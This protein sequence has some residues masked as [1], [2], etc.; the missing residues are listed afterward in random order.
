MRQLVAGRIFAFCLCLIFLL[1]TATTAFAADFSADERQKIIDSVAVALNRNLAIGEKV[2]CQASGFGISMDSLG[3]EISLIDGSGATLGVYG[4]SSPMRTLEV[5]TQKGEKFVGYCLKAAKDYPGAG[6]STWTVKPWINDRAH[7]KILWV[8]ENSWPAIPMDEMMGKAGASLDAFYEK[9]KASNPT[10]DEQYIQIFGSREKFL[11]TYAVQA[12]FGTVQMAIW[13]HEGEALKG[14]PG[15]YMGPQMTKGPEDLIKLY[16]YLCME[17]GEYNNYSQHTFGRSVKINRLYGNN[18]GVKE[19]TEADSC[20]K[21][22]LF[23][24]YKVTSDLIQVGNLSV[25][26]KG[27]GAGK[28]KFVSTTIGANGHVTAMSDI[29]NV[30]LNQDFFVF[31]GGDVQSFK[32]QLEAKTPNGRA[33]PENGRGR[34][35]ESDNNSAVQSVG[36][37]CVI[38]TIPARDELEEPHFAA[39]V[40]AKVVISKT[41]DDERPLPGAEIVI[42]DKATSKEVFRGVTDADGKVTTGEL[43][44]GNYVFVE[45]K[46]PDGYIL[47]NKEHTFVVNEDGTVT[48]EQSLANRKTS[49]EIQKIDAVTGAGVAGAQIGIYRA[50]DNQQVTT[51]T[52]GADGKAVVKGLAAGNYYAKET[53]PPAGYKLNDAEIPF[54]I[55]NDG[56]TTPVV[57]ITNSREGRQVR[58]S[59]DDAETKAPV[60][61]AGVSVYDKDGNEV[62]KGTTNADGEVLTIPLTPGEYT[63]KETSAPAGYELNREVFKFTLNEDGSISG[64]TAFSNTPLKYEVVI[65]K[66]RTGTTTPVQG[67]TITVY[68]Q[69]GE[70]VH[71]ARTDVNGEIRISNLKPG[72]YTFKETAAPVG[73]AKEDGTYSFDV[74]GDGRVSGTTS[75]TNDPLRYD[76]TLKKLDAVN[77]APLKGATLA[78]YD[79][80]GKNVLSAVTDDKGEIKVPRLLPGKYTFKETAAPYGYKLNAGSFAFEVGSDGKVTGTTTLTNERLRYDVTLKK[81]DASNNNAP[82]K[83]ATLAVYDRDGK[84]IYSAVTDDKGEIKVPQLLPGKYTFKEVV[85][86][87]GYALNGNTFTFEVGGDGKVTGATTITN[88]LLWHD[89]TIKKVDAANNAPLKGAALAVYNS[90]GKNIY[91]A[92]TDDKGEI[93]VSHLMPGKYTV[94]ETAAPSGYTLNVNS[95][96][97][98]VGSDGK[99]T[100]ATT[101]ADELIRVPVR[102]VDAKNASVELSGATFSLYRADNNVL[103][104][105]LTTGVT[106]ALVLDTQRTI[107]NPSCAK[108]AATPGLSSVS[109]A[110]ARNYTH[111][112]VCTPLHDA[113]TSGTVTF[114]GMPAGKYYIKETVAPKG[115]ALSNEVIKLEITPTYVNPANP[116][117]IKD[118]PL[119]QTGAENNT[120]IGVH[121]AAFVTSVTVLGFFGIRKLRAMLGW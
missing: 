110:D 80:T 120:L 74:A 26:I 43:D 39:G 82:L 87:A 97:F 57:K 69:A 13:Y 85:A 2:Y 16:N 76:V 51:V 28:C 63:F 59:K 75:I 65:R 11:M 73:Y 77:N 38:E 48:G 23:G 106:H 91:S 95:F 36:L 46:A 35:L 88:E 71:E 55:H 119:V 86:P 102:K 105:T 61:N 40:R 10:V 4:F 64:T 27:E 70:K 45:G 18:P 12:V 56:T 21:G 52:S 72:K 118:S 15:K 94:K 81:L 1:S 104:K 103:V 19:T 34:M 20:G 7:N 78:V 22:Y 79:S 62:F 108:I 100:G 60:S 66:T 25:A 32:L 58:I 114:T 50:G 33:M 8:L 14:N 41:G 42:K 30:A 112:A 29:P 53:V 121:I 89:A 109:A 99:V 96:A 67:A 17:R 49:V 68:N 6:G 90:A 107:H 83:G 93:K 3:V 115:Y 24:P 84:N 9:L 47:D 54:V 117:V 98:E 31:A 113:T 92:V 111:C 5:T 116:Y 101:I 37:G 44:P